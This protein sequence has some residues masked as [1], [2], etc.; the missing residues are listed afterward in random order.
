MQEL[1]GHLQEITYYCLINK[2]KTRLHENQ[3]P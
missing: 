1:D 3:V 2:D